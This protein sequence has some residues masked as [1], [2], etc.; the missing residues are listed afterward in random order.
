VVGEAVNV[1]EAVPA[2][3]LELRDVARDVA[4]SVLERH[5][6]EVDEQAK[7]PA[8]GMRA[9]G[10]A[11]L[12]GLHVGTDLGGR[13]EGMVA[14]ALVT[15]QLGQACAST[16]LVYGMHCVASKVVE[17]KAT[18]PQVEHYLG[19]IA[20]GEHVTSLALSEPGTGVHFYLPR[21]TFRQE[22]DRFVINGRKLFV[23]S[24]GEA[25]SYVLSAVAEGFEMDPGTFSCLL[26]DAETPGMTWLPEWDGF[27]MR[28]NSSRG[29]VL[30]EAIVPAR[31]LLGAEGDQT[32]YVFEIIAP[33]FIVA[34]AGS[35]LGVA[36]RAL[37]E[38][39]EHLRKR[40]YDHTGERVGAA[41]VVSHRLGELWGM[42][43]RARQL[44]YH[45]ARLGDA[46]DPRARPALFAAKAEVAETAVDVANAAM[47]LT[48]GSSYGRDGVL[49]RMLRDARASHV[50]SPTTDL[51]R[52]WLGRAVLDLPLL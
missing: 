12:L 16:A 4:K 27:G 32:W 9:L 22:A 23:T 44:L 42:V 6:A 17:S 26:A 10:E 18:A 37:D 29:V 39:V 7:W 33:Y 51:L 36:Q 3:V 47:T 19:P 24:G 40:T 14:L 31:N 50:M 48:G 35:Y 13:A 46:G 38:V 41:D 1:T 21:S 28:G 20:A 15:E 2:R 43:E 11:G 52:T 34:M 25:D 8:D 49:P 45:A 30:D 5:A